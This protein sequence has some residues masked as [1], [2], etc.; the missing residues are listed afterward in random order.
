MYA[1]S[2]HVV[3]SRGVEG[4]DPACTWRAVSHVHHSSASRDT[5]G[6]NPGCLADL[7]VLLDLINLLKMP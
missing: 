6:A 5:A 4:M 3:N 1:A 2:D 7:W